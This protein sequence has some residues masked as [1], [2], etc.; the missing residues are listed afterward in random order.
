MTRSRPLSGIPILCLIALLTSC[1]STIKKAQDITTDI[2]HGTVLFF[3]SATGHDRRKAAREQ[4]LQRIKEQQQ[5]IAAALDSKVDAFVSCVTNYAL[6]FGQSVALATEVAT[7]SM[8][9]CDS[10][11]MGFEE[12]YIEGFKLEWLQTHR[13]IT[14]DIRRRIEESAKAAKEDI[15]SKMH[16]AAVQVIIE[17]RIPQS[18][19]K[20]EIVRPNIT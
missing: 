12:N 10:R 9:A 11:L 8:S 5:T 3:K 18:V 20:P 14:E 7:A 17:G 4:Q 15:Y 19:Q 1:A 16:A 2:S 13:T 6:R